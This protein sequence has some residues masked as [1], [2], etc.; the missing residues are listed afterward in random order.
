MHDAGDM[1]NEF[2]DHGNVNERA[3]VLEQNHCRSEDP[4][5]EAPAPCARYQRCDAGYSVIMCQTEGKGHDRQDSLALT[6]LWKL[7]ESL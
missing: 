2:V 1:T 4:V 7:F 3:R 6:A 5:A